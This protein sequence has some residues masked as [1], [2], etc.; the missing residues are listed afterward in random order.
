MTTNEM[1]HPGDLPGEET[2]GS[3]ATDAAGHVGIQTAEATPSEVSISPGPELSPEPV[4]MPALYRA[5]FA[6]VS[7]SETPTETD[8]QSKGQSGTLLG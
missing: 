5:V 8:P 1:G 7:G 6:C 3:E 2:V 4:A